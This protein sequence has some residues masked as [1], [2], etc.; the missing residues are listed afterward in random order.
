MKTEVYEDT[1]KTWGFRV[2]KA[3]GR[4]VFKSSD[5]VATEEEARQAVA[6]LAGEVEKWAKDI[7]VKA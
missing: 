2:R 3:D 5:R 6:D 7:T 4:I 1:D